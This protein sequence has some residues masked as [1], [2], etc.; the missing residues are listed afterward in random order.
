M[1]G[2]GIFIYEKIRLG[3]RAD[4]KFDVIFIVIREQK[5]YRYGRVR[6]TF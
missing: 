5:F 3:R 4:R 2:A 1:Y 6:D